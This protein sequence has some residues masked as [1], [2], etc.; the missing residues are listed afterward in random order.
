MGFGMTLAAVV[1]LITVAIFVEE[2]AQAPE[3]SDHN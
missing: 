3:L 1:F 2:M